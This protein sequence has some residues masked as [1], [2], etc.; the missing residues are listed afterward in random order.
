MAKPNVVIIVQ[1]RMTSTR[2]PGKVLKTVLGKS[3]LEY[4]IERLKQVQLADELVV[5]TT[6]N[7]TDQPIV[8]LC[9]R[10]GVL[11]YRGSEHDVLGR[12]YEAARMVQADIVARITA[13]CPFIE[14][15]LIDKSIQAILVGSPAYD[16]VSNT[17][18]RCF[19]HG[20]DNEVFSFQALELAH[21]NA[22][23]TH[24]R[25]HVTPYIYQNREQFLVGEIVEDFDYSDLRWTV[26]TAEDFDLSRRIV[27]AL[28]PVNPSFQMQDILALLDRNPSWKDINRHVHQKKLGE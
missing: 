16:Y 13:D 25:E 3:L 9:E 6:K 4:E 28:Y 26:D 12:Y 27:E 11:V 10:L 2:L 23:K 1:A 5:A 7:E 17:H 24:E 21:H 15:A 8:D 14:P 19:P 18:R 20:L 22:G